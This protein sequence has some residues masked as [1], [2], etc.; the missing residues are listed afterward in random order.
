MKLASNSVPSDVDENMHIR[1]MDEE[2]DIE[3]GKFALEMFA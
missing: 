1:S 3:E 2:T